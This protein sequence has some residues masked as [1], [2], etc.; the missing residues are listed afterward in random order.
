[1]GGHRLVQRS[2]TF[3]FEDYWKLK[4]VILKH[5]KPLRNGEVLEG[6]EKFLNFNLPRSTGENQNSCRMPM[7]NATST[8][9]TSTRLDFSHQSQQLSALNVEVLTP[10]NSILEE[11]DKWRPQK[12]V[13]RNSWKTTRNRHIMS[14]HNRIIIF[15][16]HNY[17]PLRIHGTNGTFTYMKTIKFNHPW[18]AKYTNPMDPWGMMGSTEVCGN[19][20][21]QE[22]LQL[23]ENHHFHQPRGRFSQKSNWLFFLE[24][25]DFCVFFGDLILI[26]CCF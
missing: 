8:S 16:Q 22:L 25:Y 13:F 21:G 23:R 6:F 1:M 10:V 14:H 3:L 24:K 4:K 17:S 15:K 7:A 18:I 19:I 9:G 12:Y 5:L 2:Y 20:Q 26:C 11:R